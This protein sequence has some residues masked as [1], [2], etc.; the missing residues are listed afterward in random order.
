MVEKLKQRFPSV[1]AVHYPA[2]GTHFHAYV[3]LNQTRPARPARSCS[4]CS[5]GTPI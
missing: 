1:T 3:A 2:S 4:G 5:A